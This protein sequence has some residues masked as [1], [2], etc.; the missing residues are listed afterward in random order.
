LIV[1]R[2]TAE[3]VDQDQESPQWIVV[4]WSED[5]ED[6]ML[7]GSKVIG[8]SA[9]SEVEAKGIAY[10]MNINVKDKYEFH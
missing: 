3:F 1:D 6:G 5:L 10:L 8:F 2:F 7:C 9:D 4:E